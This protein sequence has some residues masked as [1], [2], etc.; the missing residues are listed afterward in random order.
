MNENVKH[1]DQKEFDEL[2]KGKTPVVCDFW[3]T[4]CAP[5]R[6]LAPVM[7]EV[8]AELKDKAIFVKVDIDKNPELSVR[9]GIY[10]IPC[11]KIFRETDEIAETI[12]F[13]PKDELKAFVEDNL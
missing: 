1:I 3:A 7:E 10:S 5:C 8:A 9:Y 11:V 4:W 13:T 2:I 12:G 6:M